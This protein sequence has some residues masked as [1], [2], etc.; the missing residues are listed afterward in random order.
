MWEDPRSEAASLLRCSSP[1]HEASELRSR[2]TRLSR[3]RDGCASPALVHNADLPQHGDTL[4]RYGGDFGA[5]KAGPNTA[6]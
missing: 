5:T 1:E 3:A 6:Q 2:Q 4:W